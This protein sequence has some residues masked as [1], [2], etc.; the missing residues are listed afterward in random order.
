VLLQTHDDVHFSQLVQLINL[1]ENPDA[2]RLEVDLPK[3]CIRLTAVD[4][5]LRLEFEP[6]LLEL[7]FFTLMARC[8]LSGESDLTRPLIDKPDIGLSASLLQELLPLCNRPCKESLHDNLK[9]LEEWNTKQ[10]R[11]RLKDSTLET[12]GTGISYT[13]FDQRKN[14][15][16]T[17][18]AQ[19]L[20]AN[21]VRWVQPSTIWGEDGQRLA[22]ES[23]DKV[24]KKGS[25]G[26]Y[27]QPYQISVVEMQQR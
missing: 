10:T 20:P 6:G 11:A 26:I 15:L 5:N 25:Y 8:T 1:G 21:L 16:G 14:Q 23:I 3:K 17:L 22:A 24:T 2:L 7:A 13:W 19:Q 4:S 27:L 12:L 9:E 18:F